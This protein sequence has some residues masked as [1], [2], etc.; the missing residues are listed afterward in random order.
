MPVRTNATPPIESHPTKPILKWA[1]G[2]R[3]LL[4]QLTPLLPDD[5][6]Q[7]RYVE[8]FLGGGAMFFCLAPT[9]ALV[10]DI[11]TELMRTYRAVRDTPN[12]VSNALDELTS[13]HSK[14][15]YYEIRG[16]YNTERDTLSET[17]LAAQFLYLNRTCFNGLHR[18]NPSGAF[19]VPI[20][21]HKSIGIPD[22]AS[23][24]QTS[25]ALARADL[26]IGMDFATVLDSCSNDDFVYLDPPYQPASKTADF[27]A[28]SRDGFGWADQLR[29]REAC[30]KL[31]RVGVRFM[32]SNSCTDKTLALYDGFD[33]RTVQAR[34]SVNSKGDRRGEV[35]ELV[36]RNY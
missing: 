5:W 6:Q 27:T 26:R 16:K 28:Y 35:P 14:I 8:P 25:N 1:G 10:N 20:G 23:L 29:L 11:N 36:I 22:L 9:R 33:I 31:N 32:L 13:T 34:R 2:K 19:N 4:P 15:Q 3:R 12:E 24:E 7:R 18:V 21:K 30:D 17:E